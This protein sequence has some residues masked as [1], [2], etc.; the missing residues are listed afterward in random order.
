MNYGYQRKIDETFEVADAAIRESLKKVGFG[1]ITEIDVKE[2]FK[3]K[4][5][6]NFR[7]YKILGACQPPTAFEALSSELEIGL[8][9]PCN[10]T[11]WEN[12]DG[13][14]TLS[15]INAKKMLSITGR[16][17]IEELAEQ[18]NDNLKIALDAV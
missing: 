12:T 8:L 4:L 1:V 2:T 9:L 6:E 3:A 14:V 17:D 13:T 15:A 7:K 11:L 10:V 18:V 16:D 5:N